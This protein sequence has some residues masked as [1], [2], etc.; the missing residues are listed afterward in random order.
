MLGYGVR[1][2]SLTHLAF[3]VKSILTSNIRCLLD[4]VYPTWRCSS[5]SSISTTT[6]TSLFYMVS[7]SIHRVVPLYLL[8]QAQSATEVGILIPNLCVA[9]WMHQLTAEIFLSKFHRTN[10]THQAK[11]GSS[12]IFRAVTN[13]ATSTGFDYFKN[14]NVT[15]SCKAIFPVEKEFPTNCC[16]LTHSV[17]SLLLHPLLSFINCTFIF[18]LFWNTF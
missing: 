5:Y 8:S 11:A 6:L 13:S 12:E 1:C 14:F 16:L 10:V 2:P 15:H 18:G 4:F 17:S 7:A 9:F 3:Q